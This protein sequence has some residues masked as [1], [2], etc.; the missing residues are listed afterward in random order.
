[1]KKKELEQRI[2]P[3]SV[4][5]LR[6]LEAFAKMNGL[7]VKVKVK[8]GGPTGDFTVFIYDKNVKKSYMVGFDGTFDGYGKLTFDYCVN[9]GVMWLNKYISGY[10][11]S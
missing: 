11:Q 10:S 9:Q 7:A 6:Y 8:E 4:S 1:M 5:K 2:G 3:D